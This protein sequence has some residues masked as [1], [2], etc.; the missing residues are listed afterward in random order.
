[1]NTAKLPTIDINGSYERFKNEVAEVRDY[2]RGCLNPG[3]RAEELYKGTMILYSEL[4]YNPDFM[5]IGINPG[6][7]FYN[8]TGIKYRP[9]ELDPDDEFEYVAAGKYG[10]DYTLAR[11]TRAAFEQSR[12]KDCLQR[13]V[14][15]NLF[16]TA[17]SNQKEMLE[18]LN[19]L[20]DKFHVDHFIK[21]VVWTK[22]LISIINP[23]V[24]I[25]EGKWVV[26]ILFMAPPRAL[27]FTFRDTWESNCILRKSGMKCFVT[28][29]MIATAWFVFAGTSLPFTKA[30]LPIVPAIE[31][32]TSPSCNWLRFWNSWA[33]SEIY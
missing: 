32:R 8:S 12:Y 31:N 29:L 26:E 6:A 7:G 11:Q 10:W 18:L 28:P 17:T 3:T 24:I 1:M 23:K 4:I 5:F 22:H 19:L 30:T 20:R 13:A 14:K 16:Y 27:D 33:S 25:C 9:E 21:S 15:T 2:T